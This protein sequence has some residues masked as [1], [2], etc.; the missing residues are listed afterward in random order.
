MEAIVKENDKIKRSSS[1]IRLCTLIIDI[2]VIRFAFTFILP[3]SHVFFPFLED[4]NYKYL[5]FIPLAIWIVSYY[6]LFEA[7]F[8]ATIGKAITRTVVVDTQGKIPP[9]KYLFK[10]SLLRLIPFEAITFLTGYNLHDSQS[11]TTVI[12][13]K[14]FKKLN[15][16]K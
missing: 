11:K 14:S 8:G 2:I 7:A 13:I 12:S 16:R 10:R 9:N 1:W 15:P 5:T 3:V 6:Y 4:P